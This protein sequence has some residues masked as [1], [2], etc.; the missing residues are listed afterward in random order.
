[1]YGGRIQQA[2]IYR[3][4]IWTCVPETACKYTAHKGR[5]YWLIAMKQ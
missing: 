2:R 4:G 1:M 5:K 3:F